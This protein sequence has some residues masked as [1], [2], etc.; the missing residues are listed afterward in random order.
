MGLTVKDAAL[1]EARRLAV[2]ETQS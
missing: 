1:A 2:A